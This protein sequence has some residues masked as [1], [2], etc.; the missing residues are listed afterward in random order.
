MSKFIKVLFFASIFLSLFFASW[1]ILNGDLSFSSD[2]ARDFLLFGEITEKKIVLIGP[3]S[4]VM[5]LFH[6]PLW[7]YLNYP[8][9]LIGNGNP[10]VVGVWWIILDV[11]F[12]V[13]IFVIS[14]KLFDITTAYLATALIALYTSFHT[15]TFFNPIGAMFTIPIFFFTFIRYLQTG[16]PKYLIAHV[17]TLGL[18]IQFE[19]A[20]GIPLTILSFLYL[21]IR[22]IKSTNKRHLLSFFVLL[23][24]LSN[25]ILFDLRHDF[26]LTN[27]VFR[28]ISPQSGDSVTYNYLYML[29]DRIRLMISQVEFVRPDPNFRN[30]IVSIIF[31]AFLALQFRHNKYKQIY[32]SFLYFYIGFFILTFINKGPILYFYL[33]PQFPLVFLIF[34]SFVTSKYKK[35]FIAIFAV[36]YLLNLQTAVSDMQASQKVRG[37]NESSWKFLNQM[38]QKVYSG[39]EKEF[40]YFVYTPDIIGYGPKYALLYQQKVSKDKKA[41]YLTKKKITYIVVAPPAR[42]NPYLSYKWWKEERIKITKVPVSTY[43]FPNG[44]LIEKYELSDEETKVDFD[45]SVDPGLSFR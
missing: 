12:L 6:G 45:R 44:Y 23:I 19:M 13:S 34:A 27:A 31:V 3:K 8:A 11:V 5:G 35:L 41:N 39:N 7:L 37:I 22:I 43:K 40:G 36:V 4:S 1:F 9:Y 17:F 38:S 15:A 30:F 26:L 18:V 21:F 29:Y 33:I 42:D 32:L 25:Y 20:I 10:L 16:K 28:Y 2:I 14:K 24:P